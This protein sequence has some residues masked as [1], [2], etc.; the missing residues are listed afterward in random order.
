MFVQHEELQTLCHNDR[1]VLATH[2]DLRV[3]VDDLNKV[4]PYK[5]IKKGVSLIRKEFDTSLSTTI[6]IRT[7]EM[8]HTLARIDSNLDN[9]DAVEQKVGSFGGFQSIVQRSVTRSKA[10]YFLTL[11]KAPHKSIVHEVMLRLIALIKEKE[12]PF[13]QLD[14][15][16]PVYSLIVQ[17]RNENRASFEQI[18]P[19]LGPFQ[20]QCSFITAINKRFSGSGLSDLIVSADIMAEKSIEKALKAL[21]QPGT[22]AGAFL[23]AAAFYVGHKIQM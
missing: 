14:G 18:L 4:R 16:Q 3:V 9:I 6:S 17:L 20:T 23:I 19:V 2:H 1:P 7:E 8:M 11:P 15:D 10:H 22:F 21:V 13:I 5:T 12:I